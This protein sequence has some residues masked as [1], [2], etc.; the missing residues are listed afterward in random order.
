MNDECVWQEQLSSLGLGYTVCK[1][2]IRLQSS[3][4]SYKYENLEFHT[5]SKD[6]GTPTSM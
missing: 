3:L 4:S 2:N 5:Q 6:Q 1:M